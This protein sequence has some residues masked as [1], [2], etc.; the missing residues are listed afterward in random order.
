MLLYVDFIDFLTEN[1]LRSVMIDEHFLLNYVALLYPMLTNHVYLK[2]GGGMVRRW[3]PWFILFLLHLGVR[4]TVSCGGIC[5]TL[6][7]RCTQMSNKKIIKTKQNVALGSRK[8]AT[9]QQTT[10]N[11]NWRNWRSVL[12]R[13]G[14]TRGK[15]IE[16][17]FL[18]FCLMQKLENRKDKTVKLAINWH[19]SIKPHTTAPT[20]ALCRDSR[21]CGGWK[22]QCHTVVAANGITM[23]VFVWMVSTL[24][25][26]PSVLVGFVI[27]YYEH[28]YK[29]AYYYI[30]HT[31][32]TPSLTCVCFRGFTKTNTKHVNRGHNKVQ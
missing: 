26:T 13:G 8:S 22:H 11:L 32:T 29:N 3:P 14:R 21:G 24:I 20:Q 31:S 25:N 28:T 19:N 27:I 12:W 23:R 2:A 16:G 30:D 5:W 10:T 18:P 6:M 9:Q 4:V 17:V 15:R 1:W 7:R